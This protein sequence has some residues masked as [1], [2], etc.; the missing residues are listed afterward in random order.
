MREST[1][2]VIHSGRLVSCPPGVAARNDHWVRLSGGQIAAVGTGDA[3]RTSDDT[4]VVDAG[5]AWIAPGFIDIHNHG[6]CGAG[7]A[8]APLDDLAS[9]VDHHGR[10]GTTRMLTSLTAAP[11]GELAERV[12]LVAGWS[13]PGVLG[14]HLEGPYLHRERRGSS[15]AHLLRTPSEGEAAELLDA[16][17]GRLRMMTIAP[18]LTGADAVI[19]LLSQA[20]VTVAVGHTTTD[21]D[22]TRRALDAGASHLTH[23][24]NAMPGWQHRAPGPVAAAVDHAEATIELVGDG[25]HVHPWML[26]AVLRLAPQRVCLISDAMEATGAGEGTYDTAHGPIEVRGGEARTPDGTLAGSTITLADAVKVAVEQAHVALADAIAAVTSVPAGVIGR[27]HDLGAV[28][29][30]YLA[31]IVLLGDDLSVAGV[32]REGDRVA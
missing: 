9:A 7:Y 18:E 14:L 3:W 19:S 13:H 15:A 6:A 30:G 27:A 4:T 22:G 21:Y 23:A 32:W 10:R 31:D 28:S 26:S 24:F 11:V 1:D 25:Q 8:E 2:T 17:G 29:E 16:A 20:G 5:G 12:R